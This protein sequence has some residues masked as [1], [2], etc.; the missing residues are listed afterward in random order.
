LIQLVKHEFLF[1]LL[2]AQPTS[3]C[4][5]GDQQAEGDD[6]VAHVKPVRLPASC[7]AWLRQRPVQHGCV[8]QI[9]C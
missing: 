9:S 2:Q 1:V 6:G 8:A 5:A 4:E 3:S 7:A